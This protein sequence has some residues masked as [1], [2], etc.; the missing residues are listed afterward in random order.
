MNYNKA[1][2]IANEIK[3]KVRGLIIT[4]SLTRGHDIINDIDFLTFRDLDDVVNDFIKKIASVNIE[5]KGTKRAILN[6]GNYF[7]VNIW[8]IPN[9]ALLP[10]FKLEFDSGKA[11]IKYKTIAKRHGMKLSI[12]GLWKGNVSLNPNFNTKNQIIKYLKKLDEEAS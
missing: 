11:N 10:F 12:N 4:G 7:K 9:K 8:Y 3:K 5:Q 1:L 6:I 2:Q